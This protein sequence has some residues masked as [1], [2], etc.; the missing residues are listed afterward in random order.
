MATGSFR[1][2]VKGFSNL[3]EGLQGFPD[4][5][6]NKVIRKALRKGGRVIMGEARRNVNAMTGNR[7]TH[8][9]PDY[10]P[11]ALEKSFVL[12]ARTYKGNIFVLVM[13]PNRVQEEL[14]RGKQGRGIIGRGG[15]HAHLV[16]LGTQERFHRD[17]SAS[18][19][20]MPAIPF[21]ALAF[22][23]KQAQV[24]ARIKFEI[25]KGMVDIIEGRIT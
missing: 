13:G 18:G 2:D 1:M 16:E 11:G 4:K 12:R 8:R 23:T 20:R 21:M 25:L 5:L 6:K 24:H 22:D 9:G 15:G 3:I 17:G 10:K 14:A 19:G 7:P